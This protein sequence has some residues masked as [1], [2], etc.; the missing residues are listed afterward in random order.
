MVRENHRDRVGE[1]PSALPN[2]RERATKWIL[3]ACVQALAA[4]LIVHGIGR[5]E[6]SLNVDECIHAFTGLFF[7][8]LLRHPPLAHPVEYAYAYY[9]HYPAIALFHWPPLFHPIEAIFFLFLGPSVLA[10]RLAIVMFALF[11]L[12]FW[13][14]L[15][16]ELEDKWTAAFSTVVLALVPQV[17]LFEKAVMLEVPCLALCIAA[18]YFWVRYLRESNNALLYG[19]AVVAGMALITKQLSG[20]LAVFCLLS[21]LSTKKWRLLPRLAMARALGITLLLAGPFYALSLAVDRRSISGNVFKGAFTV[22][23]PHL[24]YVLALPQQ[25]GW[26]VLVLAL[27]GLATCRWWA[28][29]EN[30][31]L[32]LS[33]IVGCCCITALLATKDPRY[34]IYL[35]PA[36][37]YFATAPLVSR[38]LA[39]K[40]R[41]FGCIGALVLVAGYSLRAWR[42]QRPYVSGFAS[43]AQY[44]SQISDSHVILYDGDLAGNFM[45][46]LRTHDPAGRF[47]VLRKALYATAAMKEFGAEDLIRSPAE[48]EDLLR[49]Y[50]IKY[51]IVED[52]VTVRFHAQRILRDRLNTSEFRLLRAFPIDTNIPSVR[53]RQVLLYEN[54]EAVP[55]SLNVLRVRMLTLDHDIVLPLSEPLAP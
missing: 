8:D 23:H 53:G 21:A 14:Q 40:L 50:G 7:S 28:K 37:V 25:L 49:E 55:A 38:S 36:F 22:A 43:A 54:L 30:V 9:A 5:G 16:H 52:P 12:F 19:F 27:L 15:I 32:M 44:V 13:F 1:T 42:F 41:I 29:R 10:A 18:S 17:F 3:L 51:V 6:F 2:L 11:G 45:F 39:P 4:V 24:F 46:F 20:Y 33:W 26:P 31:A 48:L 35:V 47:F 34:T